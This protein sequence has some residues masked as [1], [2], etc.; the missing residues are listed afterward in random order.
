MQYNIVLY[1]VEVAPARCGVG[2]CHRWL[3]VGIRQTHKQAFRWL[4]ATSRFNIPLIPGARE[5][6]RWN[7]PYAPDSGY[8]L[9]PSRKDDRLDGPLSFSSSIHI[10][11]WTPVLLNFFTAL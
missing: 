9:A 1:S 4:Y 8:L 2:H 3:S 5:Y 10:W 6:S 7:M 11:T